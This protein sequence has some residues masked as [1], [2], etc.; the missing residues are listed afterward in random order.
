MPENQVSVLSIDINREGTILAAVNNRGRCYIW[1]FRTEIEQDS[2][3]TDKLIP[4]YKFNA[5][6]SYVLK[7]KFS[8]NSKY[9][10][11]SSADQTTR[12]WRLEDFSLVQELKHEHQQWVWDVA[13][14]ADSKMIFTASSDGIVKLWNIE[15]GTKERQYAGHQKAVTSI[16]FHDSIVSRN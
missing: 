15:N 11:T 12:I 14:S 10:A 5:H 6:N 3:E 7:C 13:F 16:A 1:Y 2:Y 8:P 9:L 4:R